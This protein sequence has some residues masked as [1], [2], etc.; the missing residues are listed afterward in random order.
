MGVVIGRNKGGRQVRWDE[1]SGEG[2]IKGGEGHVK[3]TVGVGDGSKNSRV[4][5]KEMLVLYVSAPNINPDLRCHIRFSNFNQVVLLPKPNQLFHNV[6]HVLLCVSASV[7]C[8]WIIDMKHSPGLRNVPA[9]W[10]K[11]IIIIIDLSKKVKTAATI[12]VSRHYL[13]IG[14]TTWLSS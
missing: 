6:I 3:R 14:C 1:A 2:R 5:R 9:V 10:N 8:L 4:T 7:I 13:P 12:V 11:N